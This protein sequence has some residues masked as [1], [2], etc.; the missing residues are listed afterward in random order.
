MK[1]RSTSRTSRFDRRS[2]RTAP[3]TPKHCFFC[4]N[5]YEEIDYKNLRLLQRFVSPY[6][7]IMPSRR[8]GTCSWHQRKLAHAVKRARFMALV[9]FSV[10]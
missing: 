8:T 6:A 5:G 1:P 4:V 10:R 9:P 3:V 2:D 7:K